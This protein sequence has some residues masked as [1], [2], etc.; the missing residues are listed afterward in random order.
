MN[1]AYMQQLLA[2]ADRYQDAIERLLEEYSVTPAS[3]GYIDLIVGRESAGEL[4]RK[5]ARL[6]VAIEGLSW[7]CHVTPESRVQFGC[8]HGYGGPANPFGPGHFSETS[9]LLRVAEHGIDFD[10]PSLDPHLLAHECSRIACDYIEHDLIAEKLYS[11]CLL[12][13]LWLHVPDSWRRR[14]YFARSS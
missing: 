13:G 3:N 11:P 4:I 9:L 6:P 10:N 1:T 7:W 14:A 2:A 12:P 5:L 8:P